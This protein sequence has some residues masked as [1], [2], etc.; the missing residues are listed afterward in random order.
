MKRLSVP[1]VSIAVVRKGAIVQA[2]QFGVLAADRGG[3]VSATTVFGAESLSKP[4]TAY[5]T[6]RLCEE[7]LLD[8]DAPLRQYLARPY[9]DDGGR[10]DVITAR[11]VLSHTS[12]LPNW[13]EEVIR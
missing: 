3:R 2:E 10:G 12:G 7:G 11:H 6:L 13:R 5:A 1:A 4:V 8:L 9:L